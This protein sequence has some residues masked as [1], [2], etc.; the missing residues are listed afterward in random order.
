[1]IKRIRQSTTFVSSL[2]PDLQRQARQSYAVGIKAVFYFAAVST[3]LAYL[4]RIPVCVLFVMY[5]LFLSPFIRFRYLIRSSTINRGHSLPNPRGMIHNLMPTT[6]VRMRW[7]MTW[8][9]KAMKIVPFLRRQEP[10]LG[11]DY[12]PMNLLML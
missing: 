9:R 7:T 2:P 1:L 3:L 5:Y 4:V 8:R 11:E 10:S 6:S 12:L